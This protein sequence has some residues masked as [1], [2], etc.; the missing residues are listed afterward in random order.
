MKRFYQMAA[1]SKTGDALEGHSALTSGPELVAV[2]R[3]AN[4]PTERPRVR[5]GLIGGSQRGCKPQIRSRTKRATVSDASNRSR[6]AVKWAAGMIVVLGLSA[7]AVKSTL[8]STKEGGVPSTTAFLPTIENKTPA[9]GTSP[10]GMVWVPGGEFSMGSTSS[11][12]SLCGLPGVTRDALPVHRVYVDGFWMDKTDVTNEEFNE[13]ARATGYITIAE[14]TPTQE[15]F[16]TAPPENLVSG[17]VVF[18]PTDHPVDLGNHYQWWKYVKGAN[19]RHPLGAD[20]DLKGKE[21]YPVVQIA[22]DDAVAYANW[23]GKRLPTE[24]EWEFAAR[25]GLTGK[26]YFWGD[27]LKQHGKWMANIYQG[28]FPVKDAGEDGYAG[29]APVAQFPPNRY[30]LYDMAGN[31]WQWCGDWYQPDYYAQLAGAGGVARNP[32]GPENSFDPTE[33]TEHKRVHRGGSFLCTDQYCTRYM[34]G[35][36]GKGEISTG[37]NHLGFRC[38]KSASVEHAGQPSRTS[39]NA[40]FSFNK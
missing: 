3:L 4:R 15:E 23:A 32:T 30:G 38:V 11:S 7:F 40:S 9:P 13:F 24:A 1:D 8:K 6:V 17:S 31:V 16:P 19:W 27:E 2:E 35:A 10:K 12:E 36:R 22:Y 26:L 21:R 18:A 14:R 28:Q 25:G 5:R 33:P 39:W 37:S 34:V 20:S 29:L